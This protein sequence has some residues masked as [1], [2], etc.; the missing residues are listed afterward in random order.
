MPN[1]L[2]WTGT[3]Q[4]APF[5]QD[6]PTMTVDALKDCAACLG[7]CTQHLTRLSAENE[8]LRE[9]LSRIEDEGKRWT[10]GVWT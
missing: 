10:T 6:G 4:S 8:A 1:E 5:G 7:E 2:D 9:A 3:P